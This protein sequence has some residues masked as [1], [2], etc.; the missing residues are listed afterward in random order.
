MRAYNAKWKH[1][2]RKTWPS[3]EFPGVVFYLN[4]E[5]SGGYGGIIPGRGS[6]TD[7]SSEGE[8]VLLYLETEIRQVCLGHEEWVKRCIIR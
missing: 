5:E 3:L 7:S 2:A 4:S 8:R 1:T 6:S